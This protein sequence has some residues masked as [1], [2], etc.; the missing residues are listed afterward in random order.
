MPFRRARPRY[1]RPRAGRPQY[2][3]FGFMSLGNSTV[4]DTSG[5]GTDVFQLTPPQVNL[6]DPETQREMVL[7]RI[8]GEVIIQPGTPGT[9]LCDEDVFMNIQLA[10]YDTGNTIAE[11]LS[12]SNSD[13]DATIWENQL[14]RA[15]LHGFETNQGNT[16]TSVAGDH[17]R[18]E[19]D[20]KARRKLEFNESVLF[21][22][23]CSTDQAVRIQPNLRA[24]VR[25]NRR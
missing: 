19:V 16:S 17:T 22:A 21:A 12:P 10:S 9:T 6:N 23:N 1:R 15:Q 14:W 11:W 5:T 2:M 4:L 25:Y 20:V 3:W 13:V 8:R 7:E 18:I 24:L